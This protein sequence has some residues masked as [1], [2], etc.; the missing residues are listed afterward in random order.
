M[1]IS[2]DTRLSPAL[3][4]AVF[5]HAAMRR[6]QSQQSQTLVEPIL[7]PESSSRP[8]HLD[9]RPHLYEDDLAQSIESEHLAFQSLR[10]VIQHLVRELPKGKREIMT[11]ARYIVTELEHKDTSMVLVETATK[12]LQEALKRVS[13]RMD[14]QDNCQTQHE[15]I[16]SH[17]HETI[18][19]E[20]EA[21]MGRDEQLGQ[22]LLDTRAQ[23]Q[24]KLQ[25]HERI[26]KAMRV[27]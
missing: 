14:G 4:A 13:G 18:E 2:T 23:H 21:V 22:E 25:N 20:G 12:G 24:R 6:S 11:R 10:P 16:T 9:R 15:Q 27:E 19:A 5:P 26:H 8:D 1:T 17:L 3:P 7:T